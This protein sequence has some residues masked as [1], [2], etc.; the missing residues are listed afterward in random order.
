MHSPRTCSTSNSSSSSVSSIQYS[1]S[2]MAGAG[3]GC[4]TN[5]WHH[6][7]APRVGTTNTLFQR[8]CQVC[9][10]TWHDPSLLCRPG[11]PTRRARVRPVRVGTTSSTS[12]AAAAQQQADR[13]QHQVSPQT[14]TPEAGVS[15]NVQGLLPP[16]LSSECRG[17]QTT[18][19]SLR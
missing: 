16:L 2:H 18:A 15:V 11:S 8:V 6:V 7:L 12:G 3:K 9:A 19:A 1:K 5:S 17:K 4:K 14:P 10:C 13:R